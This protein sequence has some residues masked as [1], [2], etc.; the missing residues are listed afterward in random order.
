MENISLQMV[1]SEHAKNILS[2][3]GVYDLFGRDKVLILKMQDMFL[4]LK[5]KLLT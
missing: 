2:H 1:A 4:N 3:L 5:R